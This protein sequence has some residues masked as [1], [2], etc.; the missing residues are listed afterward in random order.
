M[1]APTAHDDQHP[2]V[3]SKNSQAEVLSPLHRDDEGARGCFPCAVLQGCRQGTF[4]CRG[5][6]NH[7]CRHYRLEP[8]RSPTVYRLCLFE[9]ATGYSSTFVVAGGVNS[10]SRACHSM[11]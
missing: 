3:R 8:E 11:R 10:G 1:R 6:R 4:S 2:D 9:L 7:P 5:H